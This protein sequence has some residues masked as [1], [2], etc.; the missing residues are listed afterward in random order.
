[1]LTHFNGSIMIHNSISLE[2]IYFVIDMIIVARIAIK[3]TFNLFKNTSSAL[4]LVHAVSSKR[5]SND[6][7]SDLQMI[8]NHHQIIKKKILQ[9]DKFVKAYEI[10]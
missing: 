3:F 6:L 10:Y 8:V 1:M 5:T 7:S 2:C 4:L 9:C